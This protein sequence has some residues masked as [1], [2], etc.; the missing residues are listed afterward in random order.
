M[1]LSSVRVGDKISTVF[2][3]EYVRLDN[4]HLL[5]SIDLVSR[6]ID[7]V[8]SLFISG[9]INDALKQ[10]KHDKMEAVILTLKSLV[11]NEF[12]KVGKY[13]YDKDISISLIPGKFELKGR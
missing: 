10:A 2:L 3:R 6:S 5:E 13:L 12:A 9:R 4:N 8:F 11:T 7:R 1:K